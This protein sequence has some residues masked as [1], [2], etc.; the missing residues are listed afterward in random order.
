MKRTSYA[1]IAAVV[2]VCGN[3][4]MT[5]T[6]TSCSNKAAVAADSDS[7]VAVDSDS[8]AV[9]DTD[10]CAQVCDSVA[11]EI[12]TPASASSVN[13]K[14]EVKAAQTDITGKDLDLDMDYATYHGDLKNGLPDGQGRLIF[15]RSHVIPN[16]KA[17]TA[18]KGDVVEGIFRQGEVMTATWK[19]AAGGTQTISK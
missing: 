11:T 10:T 2:F 16:L 8:I 14:G 1:A 17:Y 7:C 15:K 12:T 9:C 3:I 13:V 4:F 5:T 18:A 6:M 19:K